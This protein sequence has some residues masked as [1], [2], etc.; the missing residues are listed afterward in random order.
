VGVIPSAA[1]DLLFMQMLGK[2]Q[3]PLPLLRDR[4]DNL[5]AFP[6]PVKPAIVVSAAT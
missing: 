3:I 4:N 1:R 5:S 6:Q 2:T